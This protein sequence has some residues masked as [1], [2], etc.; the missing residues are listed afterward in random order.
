ME[1][2][3][4]NINGI[5]TVVTITGQGQ[6]LLCL[7][8]WGASHESFDELRHALRDDPV[9]VIAPD[10]PGF[11][12]SD[13]PPG[14]WSVD[15]YVDFVESGIR[16]PA[17]RQAQ[18][19]IRDPENVS[20]LAH[21]FGGRIAIK[22]AAR[23]YP[24]I[25]HLYLCAAAG[26][27]QKRYLKREVGHLISKVGKSVLKIPGLKIC[28]GA[29]KKILYKVLRAHDYEQ[30]S[31]LM[32]ET[33]IKVINE[34]LEPY[35]DDIKVPTDLFWGTDDCMTPLS[36]GVL[37]NKKIV[38]SRLHTYKNVRHRVHGDRAEEIADVIRKSLNLG[39]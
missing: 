4:V 21:S 22:L 23:G 6:D 7:H 33:M 30:A 26:L 29:T 27:R 2:K 9:R 3:R 37:M 39:L 15:D 38:Q 24:S 11:G 36:D 34:D 5:S 8:G 17:L 35:L 10:L 12:E 14:S 1:K 32:K 19:G 16:N 13:E 28:E 18:D 25:S 31:P 20:L